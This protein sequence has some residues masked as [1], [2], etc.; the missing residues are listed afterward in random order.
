M[1]QP[2]LTAGVTLS[3]AHERSALM[4]ID[5]AGGLDA[6]QLIVLGGSIYAGHGHSYS[7]IDLYVVLKEGRSLPHYLFNFADCVVQF[8]IILLDTL[9]DIAATF[10]RFQVTPT[11]RDQ[12]FAMLRNLKLA[13]R[14]ACGEVIHA[15][16]EA[17]EL[18]SRID[19]ETIRKLLMVHHAVQ[20]SRYVEDACGGLVSS[21]PL[22][23][24]EASQLALR[25]AAEALLA[26][27]G[28]IF[29]G[30]AF[31]WRRLA[32]RGGEVALRQVWTA[33][34]H[35]EFGEPL[36]VVKRRVFRLLDLATYLSGR[37]LL[38]GWQAPIDLKAIAP[39]REPARLRRNPAFS[40]LR[41]GDVFAFDGIDHSMRTNEFTV[42]QWLEVGRS[43]PKDPAAIEAL[44][45]K[46]LICGVA[47]D[48][49]K[50]GGNMNDQF[51]ADD[52]ATCGVDPY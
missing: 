45:R 47:S 34:D 14:V 48:D 6:F 37:G 7:D 49:M 26:A 35:T 19:P 27:A 9:R 36:P 17:R 29:V 15:R 44:L 5:A 24:L 16:G 11:C 2:W 4:A 42:R 13:T 1:V 40:V 41:F 38:D 50:G 32:K 12:L 33:N 46:N 22:I 25:H 43:L 51:L 3:E 52:D 10:E 21:D 31:L 23:A 28:D 18:H 30:D 39:Y 8:N 20:V